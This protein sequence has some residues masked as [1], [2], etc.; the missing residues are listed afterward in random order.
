VKIKEKLNSIN[1]LSILQGLHLDLEVITYKTNND[2]IET[3]LGLDVTLRF[4][5][6]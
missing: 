6:I 2:Q 4:W 5:Q 3:E 1:Y